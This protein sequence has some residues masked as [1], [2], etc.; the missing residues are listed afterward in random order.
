M[1]LLALDLLLLTAVFFII[2]KLLSKGWIREPRSPLQAMP[3]TLV[4]AAS[5]QP[6]DVSQP[7]IP[8]ELE[9]K[10]NDS[11]QLAPED[12]DLFADPIDGMVFT[13]DEEIL[14]CGCGTG[15]RVETWDWIQQYHQGTCIRCGA[16]EPPHKR[17]VKNSVEK[18]G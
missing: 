12:S 3:P 6:A 7:I 9:E 17:T 10:P 11:K 18:I 15:Y 13:P 4:L 1:T 5:E 16:K 14:V 8:P 2:V